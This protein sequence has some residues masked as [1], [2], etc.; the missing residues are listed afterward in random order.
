[1][2]SLFSHVGMRRLT[3]HLLVDVLNEGLTT[4][5]DPPVHDVLTIGSIMVVDKLL[6]RGSLVKLDLAKVEVEGVDP[7]QQDIG[8]DL[9]NTFLSES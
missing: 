1:M 6:A 8:Q 7:F 4:S 2:I 9:S 3:S 5:Q